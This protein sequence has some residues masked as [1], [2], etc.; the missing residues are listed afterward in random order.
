MEQQYQSAYPSLVPQPDLGPDPWRVLDCDV[1]NSCV[2]PSKELYIPRPLLQEDML[3]RQHELRHIKRWK[4]H[5]PAPVTGVPLRD[6]F[7]K[8]MDEIGLEITAYREGMNIYRA[9]D[10]FDWGNYPFPP[11]RHECA[12][13]WLQIGGSIQFTRNTALTAYFGRIDQTMNQADRKILRDALKAIQADDSFGNCERWTNVLTGHFSP[14]VKP[15]T[16]PQGESKKAKKEREE[17]EEEEAEKGGGSGSDG[18]GETPGDGKDREEKKEHTGWTPPPLTDN[19]PPLLPVDV[20]KHNASKYA[21]KSIMSQWSRSKYGS[22]L[23]YPS[24]LNPYGTVFGRRAQGGGMIIDVSSS[25]GWDHEALAKAIEKMPGLWCAAYCGWNRTRNQQG[26]YSA[27]LCIV[28]SNGKIGKYSQYEPGRSDYN[29]GTGCDF[30][31]LIYAIA[32]S[33]K[34][35]VWVSDGHAGAYVGQI[36]EVTRRYKVPR[37]RT[38]A[39][40]IDFLMGKAVPGNWGHYAIGEHTEM[41]RG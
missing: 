27:R 39:D 31:S 41:V 3:A 16:K 29:S 2:S 26:P 28:A 30:P 14:P 7:R 13:E 20:H 38:M 11:S 5:G 10:N 23:R 12:V 25:M 33:P 18:S 36:N 17:A 22:V 6:A 9:R 37:V 32:N 19:Q 21:P 34:P 1:V 15:D 40:G 4:T 24:N 8:M 35:L